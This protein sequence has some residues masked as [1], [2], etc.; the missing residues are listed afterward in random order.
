MHFVSQTR[1]LL[2]ELIIIRYFSH[3]APVKKVINYLLAKQL[4]ISKQHMNL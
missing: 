1:L 2:L 3:N 4:L